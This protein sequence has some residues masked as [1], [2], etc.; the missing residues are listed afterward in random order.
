MD[1][2]RGQRELEV[3]PHVLVDVD[4]GAGRDGDRGDLGLSLVHVESH[5]TRGKVD[6]RI[7][8]DLKVGK[9]V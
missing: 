7:L 8:T 3:G 5:H 6:D 2:Q 4:V 1:F 9:N